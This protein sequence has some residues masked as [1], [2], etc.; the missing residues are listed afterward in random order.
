MNVMLFI[1][2][3]FVTL[4]NDMSYSSRLRLIGDQTTRL[5]YD[6]RHVPERLIYDPLLYMHIYPHGTEGLI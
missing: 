5:I 2:V 3:W 1:L 6:P 4:K